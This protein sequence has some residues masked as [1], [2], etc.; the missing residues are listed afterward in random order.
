MVGILVDSQGLSDTIYT[1]GIIASICQNCQ[2]EFVKCLPDPQ[3]GLNERKLLLLEMLSST[4]KGSQP[5]T[6]RPE[7][8][9]QVCL[10][11]QSPEMVSF[12]FV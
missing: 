7:T 11:L 8:Q 6:V 9:I 12:S 10:G 4:F 1:M 3:P 5:E 2:M